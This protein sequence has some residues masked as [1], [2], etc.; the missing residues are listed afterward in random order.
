[1]SGVGVGVGSMMMMCSFDWIMWDI[2]LRA[3]SL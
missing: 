3:L 2:K 1:M